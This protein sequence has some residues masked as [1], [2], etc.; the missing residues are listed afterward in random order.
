MARGDYGACHWRRL[1]RFRFDCVQRV[2]C[3]ACIPV[4]HGFRGTMASSARCLAVLVDGRCV[5]ILWVR[6]VG[7]RGFRANGVVD[8]GQQP[9]SRRVFDPSCGCCNLPDGS[10]RSAPNGVQVGRRSVGSRCSHV[11]AGREYQWMGRGT[12]PVCC[13]RGPGGHPQWLATLAGRRRDV[14]C[15]RPILGSSLWLLAGFLNKGTS[16]EALRLDSPAPQG[17]FPDRRVVRAGRR[18]RRARPIAKPTQRQL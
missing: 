13:L 18:N 1:A 3:T 15:R 6:H 12:T 2:V 9:P 17:M 8:T 14:A 5:T 7:D 10:Q 11:D 16:C 4:A